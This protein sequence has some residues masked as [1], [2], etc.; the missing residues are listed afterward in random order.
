MHVR[1]LVSIFYVT[2][3]VGKVSIDTEYG[4]LVSH[5]RWTRLPATNY[6]FRD[7]E[8][9][10]DL[11]RHHQRMGFNGQLALLRETQRIW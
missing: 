7:E 6:A 10:S 8:K 4:P 2:L 1:G 11:E 3:V 9:V 5:P